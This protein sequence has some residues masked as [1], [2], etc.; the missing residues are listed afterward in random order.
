MLRGVLRRL[1]GHHPAEEGTPARVVEPPRRR[2]WAALPALA[3]SGQWGAI[4]ASH[5]GRFSRGVA[6]GVQPHLQLAP[7]GHH[8][9]PEGPRGRTVGI[10]RLPQH[11]RTGGIAGLP[12]LGPH[13]AHRNSAE[14]APD[15]P[16]AAAPPIFAPMPS[17]PV[18][19][20]PTVRDHSEPPARVA[21]T[22][23]RPPNLPI[24][25]LGVSREAVPSGD[26][27]GASRPAA[28]AASVPE[29]P[30]SGRRDTPSSPP[31]EQPR[32]PEPAK[33]TAPRPR[34]GLRPAIASVPP[35]AR[36]I[37]PGRSGP[38]PAAGGGVSVARGVQRFMSSGEETPSQPATRGPVTAQRSA[39]DRTMPPVP[40]R[41]LPARRSGDDPQRASADSSRRL[42]RPAGGSDV[43]TWPVGRASAG[44]QAIVPT[45]PPAVPV[46]WN[47]S[48]STT[49]RPPAAGEGHSPVGPS[50]GAGPRPKTR[51]RGVSRGAE[52]AHSAERPADDVGAMPP[53]LGPAPPSAPSRTLHAPTRPT[54][55]RM[56]S[57]SP[58]DRTQQEVRLP[59]PELRLLRAPSVA[60]LLRQPEPAVGSMSRQ[61]DEAAPAAPAPA[62][63]AERATADPQTDLDVVFHKLYPRVRDELRW[64]L[65]VQRERAGLL[66]D[67]R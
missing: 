15:P 17:V 64:E 38:T 58:S 19:R 9:S 11:E 20:A 41:P 12:T 51:V 16:P 52:R 66:V 48:G 29:R 4:G 36:P 27:G 49:S 61:A 24:R 33:P 50:P 6:A 44:P 47:R 39:I 25:P 30:A 43:R 37:T 67:P 45:E 57:P 7:L 28:A 8:V 26:A 2:D 1:T 62:A 5:A 46:M 3:P 14:K 63:P 54:I 55:Q 32:Q 31:P 60:A 18:L 40:A 34:P 35:T 23:D 22:P 21:R 65:R 42:A 13:R 10:V 53:A 59:T 56:T